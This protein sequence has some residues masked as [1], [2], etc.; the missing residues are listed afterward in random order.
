M[1][2][3]APLAQNTW[4]R[5]APT[6][7]AE[8]AAKYGA[9]VYSWHP[10]RCSGARVSETRFKLKALFYPFHNQ[11]LILK[12]G[13]FQTQGQLAPPH[14]GPPLC[15]PGPC[16]CP[17]LAV[18]P[19]SA[20][21]AHVRIKLA[22]APLR[23]VECVNPNNIHDACRVP[24]IRYYAERAFQRY[25]PSEGEIGLVVLGALTP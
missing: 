16:T 15:L 3:P 19:S 9:P 24:T 22:S 1:T 20:H 5:S 6:L 17:G 2:G 18:G 4:E 7:S 11:K 13:C 10:P 14:R 12:T 23:R 21:P 25:T 8:I